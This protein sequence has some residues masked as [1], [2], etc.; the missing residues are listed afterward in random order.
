MSLV[1]KIAG[2]VLVQPKGLL[3]TEAVITIPI[4]NVP[5]PALAYH[6]HFFEF[7]SIDDNTIFLAHQLVP[8][9]CYEVIVTTAG[10]LYRYATKDVVMVKGFYCQVPLLQFLG[11]KNRTS[12]MVGEKVSEIQ[13]NQIFGKLAGDEN[14]SVPILFV[15]PEMQEQSGVYILYIENKERINNEQCFT[16]TKQFEAMLCCN[17]YYSQAL[18]TGQLRT[19]RY[20]MVEK[21]FKDRLTGY[22]REKRLI[23]DGDIKLPLLFLAHELKD[24][25]SFL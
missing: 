19:M 12:D 13:I 17:P 9:G 20:K 4:R 7:R 14:E 3:S 21:S 5:Q 8:G 24:L 23:K 2:A 25:N 11:R 16:I 10:G 15:K 6:S 1:R 22:Y 18:D